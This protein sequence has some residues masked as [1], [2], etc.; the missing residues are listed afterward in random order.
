[1]TAVQQ[2]ILLKEYCIFMMPVAIQHYIRVFLTYTSWSGHQTRLG[3][4]HGKLRSLDDSGPHP[5][6]SRDEGREV[7]EDERDNSG[8]YIQAVL[9]ISGTSS[10][11]SLSFVVLL[12]LTVCVCF[13]TVLCVRTALFMFWSTLCSFVLNISAAVSSVWYH[14]SENFVSFSLH[15][16][17]TCFNFNCVHSNFK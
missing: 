8:R 17:D 2:I 14:H 7:K 4:C 15:H 13:I 3:R 1:M 10:C 12:I 16:N 5:T 11:S 9:L 6:S